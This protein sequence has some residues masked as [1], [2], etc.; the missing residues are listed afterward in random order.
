M[1]FTEIHQNRFRKFIYPFVGL[2]AIFIVGFYIFGLFAF[3]MSSLTN[4]YENYTFLHG[5]FPQLLFVLSF[6]SIFLAI[7]SLKV[8]NKNNWVKVKGKITKIDILNIDTQKSLSVYLKTEYTYSFKHKQYF[9]KSRYKILFDKKTEYNNFIESASS[10]K[11]SLIDIFAFKRIPFVSSQTK[12]V[13]FLEG[14][15]ILLIAL[16]SIFFFIYGLLFQAIEKGF[17]EIVVVTTANG[18][19][20]SIKG[21]KSLSTFPSTFDNFS[22]I[23]M[24]LISILAIVFIIQASRLILKNK[25]YYGTATID[26]NSI[27]ESQAQGADQKYCSYCNT[28]NDYDSVYCFNCGMEFK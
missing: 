9:K 28:L 23:T 8:I 1:Q 22:I 26:A 19:D 11:T 10:T 15:I 18:T 12:K 13:N 6:V 27:E 24:A 2:I 16:G 14:T 3:I 5:I 17:A 20:T 4:L 21:L 7:M 25:V